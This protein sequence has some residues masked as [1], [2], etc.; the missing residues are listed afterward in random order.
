MTTNSD[1]SDPSSEAD[2]FS[3]LFDANFSD[4]WNYLRRRVEVSADADDLSAEVFTVAWRRR[5][6]LPPTDEQRLWLFGVARNTLH[7]HQ[8]STVRR[9]RLVGRL[10]EHENGNGDS[11]VDPIE[12]D[13]ALWHALAALT[14]DDRDVL[15]MR[16]WDQLSVSDM[17]I[18]LGCTPNAVSLRLHKARERLKNELDRITEATVSQKD[19]KLIGN[20]A[21]ESTRKG[22]AR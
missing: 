14:E 12:R 9:L 13:D 11:S 6:E 8:R 7:N 20:E 22:D 15:L 2:L 5:S 16:A 4:V 1:N 10:Q 21:L 19:R 3:E 17:A 18:L